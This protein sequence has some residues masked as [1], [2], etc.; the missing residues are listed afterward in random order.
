M[1]PVSHRSN[2]LRARVWSLLTKS[3]SPPYLPFPLTAIFVAIAATHL[4]LIL[5]NEPLS[6]WRGNLEGAGVVAVG[7]WMLVGPAQVIGA[8]LAYFVVALLCLGV[9]NIRWSLIGWMTAVVLHLQGVKVWWRACGFSRWSE[10]LGALC[11]GFDEGLFWFFAALLLGVVLTGYLAPAA[12]AFADE[13]TGRRVGRGLSLAAIAW[14]VGLVAATIWSA[15][16]PAYG[17]FHVQTAT[18]PLPLQEAEGAYDTRRNRF[19]MF[20]GTTGYIGNDRW[21]FSGKTWEWDGGNWLDVSP[22]R[23]PSPRSRAGMAYDEE[24]G[25]VVLFG[26]RDNSGPLS[27]TWEWDGRKWK[28]IPNRDYSNPPARYGHEMFYDPIRKKVV[29]YGGY[30]HELET[31]FSDAWEWDGEDW[32]RIQLAG[33]PPIASFFALAYNPHK[34]YALGL[35]SSFPGGTWVFRDNG[36]TRL[37]LKMQ[38]SHRAWTSLAYDPGRRLFVTFSGVSQGKVL[39]DTWF[40]DGK[41]WRV[42]T[43]TAYHPSARS[44]MVIWYDHVR[45]RVMLFGGHNEAEIYNDTWEL[46]PPE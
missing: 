38:P 26:G 14:T 37:P 42:F 22:R 8:W 4:A 19:V 18:S 1:E 40:Y 30:F 16:P 36:W 9:F 41:N 32:A 33:E 28:N 5:M 31:C 44:D 23:G 2:S 35:W 3:L 34:Q 25:V 20:G 21:S 43:A 39:D 29:L 7:D 27:D 12:S 11:Q 17:W 45:G 46:I 6:F 10:T 24:R 13:R 15:R